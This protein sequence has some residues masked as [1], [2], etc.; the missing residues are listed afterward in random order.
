M[1]Q[2]ETTDAEQDAPPAAMERSGIVAGSPT[3]QPQGVR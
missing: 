1:N 2:V 3:R